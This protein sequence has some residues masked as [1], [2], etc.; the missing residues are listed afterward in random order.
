MKQTLEYGSLPIKTILE[1]VT[2]IGNNEYIPEIGKNNPKKEVP[3]ALGIYILEPNKIYNVL[4]D[5]TLS[6]EDIK[7]ISYEN[8]IP[9]YLI[10]SLIHP[11]IIAE[12]ISDNSVI[13]SYVFTV[14]QKLR[15]DINKVNFGD[16]YFDY[17]DNDTP[18]F[19]LKLNKKLEEEFNEEPLFDYKNDMKVLDKM[20]EDY[21]KQVESTSQD[22]SKVF[23]NAVDDIMNDSEEL[24]VEVGEDAE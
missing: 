22:L 4:T 19:I 9:N 11:K 7:R 2:E 24:E 21:K 20:E 23:D 17:D 14:P 6:I 8:V 18:D 12:P 3:N 13:L 5:I 16:V 15:L 1:F 10:T